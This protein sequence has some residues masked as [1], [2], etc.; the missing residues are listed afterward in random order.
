MR[1]RAPSSLSTRPLAFDNHE[2][3]STINGEIGFLRAKSPNQCIT[4][5][6]ANMYTIHQTYTEGR[7]SDISYTQ[8]WM[9]LIDCR[10]LLPSNSILS[11]IYKN[12]KS[13]R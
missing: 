8:T 10:L 6:G 1:L 11:Q 5:V 13:V 3:S 9:E 2:N 12:W 7:Y 4:A